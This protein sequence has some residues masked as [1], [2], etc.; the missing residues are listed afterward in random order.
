[1]TRT[2]IGFLHPGAMGVSLAASAIKSGNQV[3]WCRAGRS[4]STAERAQ[5]NGLVEL[6]TLQELCDRC[7]TIVCVCPPAAALDVARQVVAVGFKGLYVDA[8]AVSPDR[9]R[10][11]GALVEGAGIDF[12][13]GGIIGGPAW[14]ANST[15]LYLSGPRASEVASRFAGG[16]LE[17]KVIGDEI[18]KASALKMCF[19]ARTKGTTALLCAVVAA[20]DALG[21]RDDL[22]RQWSRHD[23]GESERLLD[24]VRRVTAKAW[25]FSGEM[26]EIAATLESAGLPGG[27]HQSAHEIYER[28]AGFK[29]RDAVPPIDEVIQ[30]LN[31]S[32]SPGTP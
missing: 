7:S 15:W 16:P 25:R 24:S 18:G 26:T 29:D 14:N 30:A 23:A 13:D 9:A 2:S 19:A 22:E 4:Q 6:A 27:F 20:A 5:A 1:M 28:M 12:V 8:N 17:T 32:Q 3:Y 21:V 10:Q 11:I 31:R